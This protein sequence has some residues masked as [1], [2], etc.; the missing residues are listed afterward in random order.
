MRLKEDKKSWRV[1]AILKRDFKHD[2]SEPSRIR[3]R[4][5]KDTKRWCRGKVGIE[6]DYRI[7]EKKKFLDWSWETHVCSK[8][9]RKEIK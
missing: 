4:S 7:K 1:S 6:H 9:K 5:K 3:Y 2:S 8:C